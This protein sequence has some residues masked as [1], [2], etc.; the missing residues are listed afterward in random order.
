MKS[1]EGCEEVRSFDHTI[2][3]LPIVEGFTESEK[4][5]QK[6]IMKT[7]LLASGGGPWDT[8][9]PTGQEPIGDP[10]IIS[11]NRYK[12][13]AILGWGI[14]FLARFLSVGSSMAWF[15]APCAGQMFYGVSKEKAGDKFIDTILKTSIGWSIFF[16]AI[17]MTLLAGSTIF[18]PVTIVGAVSVTM[19]MNLLSAAGYGSSKLLKLI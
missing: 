9:P 10:E 16:L 18:P 19:L 8:P 4:K 11:A 1:V 14:G 17:K 13:L 12:K 3:K 5:P 15:M 6:G 2:D 7:T